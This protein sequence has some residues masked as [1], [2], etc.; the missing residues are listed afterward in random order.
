MCW[1]GASAT[2][3]KK[4]ELRD[5]YLEGTLKAKIS[6]S[7]GITIR[8]GG[9]LQGGAIAPSLIVEEGGG[10]IGKTSITQPGRDRNPSP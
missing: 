2:F 8:A 10:L 5:V 7:R 3:R 4:L 1:R 6:A 9:L